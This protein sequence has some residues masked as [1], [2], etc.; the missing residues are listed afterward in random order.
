MKEKHLELFSDTP[1]VRDFEGL[2]EENAVGEFALMLDTAV[3]LHELVVEAAEKS[4]GT[5]LVSTVQ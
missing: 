1:K 2:Q 4:T 3:L 5:R